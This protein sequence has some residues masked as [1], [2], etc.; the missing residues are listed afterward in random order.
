MSL[1]V[2]VIAG[3]HRDAEEAAGI[4]ETA[5]AEVAP[6]LPTESHA[7]HAH[8][9]TERVGLCLSHSFF[10]ILFT[11]ILILVFF[12]VYLFTFIPLFYSFFLNYI[13]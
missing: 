11:L 8:V 7:G 1:A 13:V 4:V 9:P 12:S 10:H 5:D 6:P 2:C 3:V